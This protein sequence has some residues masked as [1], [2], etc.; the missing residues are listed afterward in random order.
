MTNNET[1]IQLAASVWQKEKTSAKQFDPE[2]AHEFV[3]IITEFQEQ[4]ECFQYKL[5]VL[6]MQLTACS[7]AA[8]C[9]TEQSMQEQ[10]LKDGSPYWSPSYR[11]VLL[12]V[13][14]EIDLRKLLKRV[15]SQFQRHTREMRGLLSL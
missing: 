1:A 10:G 4:T 5:E 12:A 13:K 7:V 9:N 3:L 11:D 6:R 8:M 2:L 15:V 14:R